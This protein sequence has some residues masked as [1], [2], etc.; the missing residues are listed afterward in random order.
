M[1]AQEYLKTFPL[2]CTF[3]P[4]LND[5]APCG[6]PAVAIYVTDDERRRACFV[7]RSCAEKAE[8]DGDGPVFWMKERPAEAEAGD[9]MDM[10]LFLGEG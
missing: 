2:A 5:A 4:H 1:I 9:G 3:Y 6:Q 10:R 8:Q 7:C